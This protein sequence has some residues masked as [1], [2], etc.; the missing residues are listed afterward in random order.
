V[1]LMRLQTPVYDIPLPPVDG[2]NGTVTPWLQAGSNVTLAGFG[3]TENSAEHGPQFLMHVDG[4]PV[5]SRSVCRS[6]NPT[7]SKF[8]LM[9]YDHAL[10]VG[11]HTG[12]DSCFGDSGGPSIVKAEGTNWV[13]GVLCKGSELPTDTNFCAVEGRYA[14]YTRVSVYRDFLKETVEVCV[15]VCV[16][17]CIY[18]F[19]DMCMYML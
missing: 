3:V 8:G 16:Y 5:A 6:A 10:C 14:V 15:C 7:S 19:M 4:I 12:K 1:A 17:V 9:N 11:G 2:L 13:V 18:A